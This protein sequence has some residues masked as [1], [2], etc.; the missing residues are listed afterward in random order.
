ME[1]QQ[2]DFNLTEE[3]AQGIYANLVAISHS[4]SEFI[5]DFIAMLPGLPKGT[6]RSRIILTPKN[7][8]RLL[9]ALNQNIRA[10]EGTHGKLNDQVTND[11]PYTAGGGMA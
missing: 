4:D 10:Y 8:K 1:P 5:F 2:V 7:A 9:H 11:F 3:T 6:V